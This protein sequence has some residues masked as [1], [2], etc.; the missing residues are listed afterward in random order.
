MQKDSGKVLTKK[1]EDYSKK[2][3]LESMKAHLRS[4]KAFHLYHKIRMY[5]MYNWWD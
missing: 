5:R 1:I 2:K 3:I 4:E